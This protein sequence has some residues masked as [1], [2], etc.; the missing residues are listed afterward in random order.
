[1]AIL[2]LLEDGSAVGMPFSWDVADLRYSH[3]PLW[4]SAAVV[5]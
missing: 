3:S 1:M 2:L 5:V 4:G